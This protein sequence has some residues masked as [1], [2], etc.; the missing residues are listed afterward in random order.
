VRH[1]ESRR[2]ASV[3][4]RLQK[5]SIPPLAEQVEQASAF[6]VLGR[7]RHAA[8]V[9]AAHGDSAQGDAAYGRGQARVREEANPLRGGIRHGP[10]PTGVRPGPDGQPLLVELELS[11]PS[12]FLATSRDAPAHLAGAIC[13]RCR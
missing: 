9:E 5:D 6:R 3:S 7:G 1:E 4:T 2:V 8:G 11:E 10:Q 13:V 12:L